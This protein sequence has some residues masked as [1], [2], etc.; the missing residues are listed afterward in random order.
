MVKPPYRYYIFVQWKNGQPASMI[1]EELKNAEGNQVPSKRMIFRW[2]KAFEEGRET[3][4]DEPR[5]GQPREAVGKKRMLYI[6]FRSRR[7]QFKDR[8]SKAQDRDR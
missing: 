2:I 3:F 4:E 1:H 7:R 6:F 5:S 8:S